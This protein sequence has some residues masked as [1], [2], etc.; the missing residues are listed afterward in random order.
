M[1]KKIIRKV[2]VQTIHLKTSS[3]HDLTPANLSV[4]V[5][6]HPDNKFLFIIVIYINCNSQNNEQ[7]G[8]KKGLATPTLF[9]QALSQETIK[10]F[11]S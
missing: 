1:Y 3:L 2:R 5:A 8:Y 4:I 10:Q 7:Y 9:T 11:L 6:P